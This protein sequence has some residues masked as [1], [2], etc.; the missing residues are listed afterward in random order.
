MK[1][2]LTKRTS[3][4]NWLEVDKTIYLMMIPGLL[5]FLVFRYLPMTGLIVAFKDYDIFKGL[6]DSP[7][8]GF[9]HFVNAFTGK[10]FKRVFSNTLSIS[11][12][13]LLWGFPV[14]II[15]ALLLNEVRLKWFRNIAQTLIYLPHFIS[16]VVVAG[17]MQN[18]LSPN[19]G[20]MG[21]IQT[22]LGIPL[23]NYL[24]D[25][26]SIRSILVASEIWKHAGWDSIVY[27][28]AITQI[29][30]NLYEAATIDGARSFQKI[31]YVTLPSIAGVI[32]LLLILKIGRLMNMGF[33]QIIV[34]SNPVVRNKIDVFGTFVYREGLQRG[35]YSYA[36]A[37]DFFK[38]GVALI[39][40]LTANKISKLLG[41]EGIL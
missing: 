14:P 33:E 6:F 39:L 28:A 2:M 27:L 15:L 31:W 16:W 20:V 26:D 1:N 32:I 38:S 10:E 19:F 5:Y 7:W 8:V 41:E 21:E 25:L 11:F 35:L 37:I 29:D 36:A 30:P 12:L 4:K 40:V 22:K 3:K 18:L 24:A 13:K 9:K 34:L 23:T 17:I